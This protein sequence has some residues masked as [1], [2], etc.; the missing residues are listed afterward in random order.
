MARFYN[1]K[2]PSNF[3]DALNMC[4]DHAKIKHNLS[5]ERIADEMGLSTVRLYQMLDSGD[6]PISRLLNFQRICRCNYVTRYL[7]HRDNFM[8]VKIPT[9]GKVSDELM[10]TIN[11]S[12]HE[13][14][15]ELTEFYTHGQNP[16]IAIAALTKHMT[17]IAW[18][19]G[20]VE[21]QMQPDLNFEDDN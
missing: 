17:N 3:G 1:K 21:K 2:I 9:G 18:H 10:L 16:D 6:M 5:V 19:K 4:K 7:A 12:F 11:K 20:N 8:L 14:L 13:A 15:N